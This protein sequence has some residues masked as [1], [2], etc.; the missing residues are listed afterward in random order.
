MDS[1]RPSLT[2]TT[3]PPTDAKNTC[4]HT[5]AYHVRVSPMT[6]TRG[7]PTPDPEYLSISDAARRYGVSWRT[8]RH[9]I[10]TAGVPVVVLG[11]RTIRVRVDHLERVLGRQGP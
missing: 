2:Y 11:P 4:C 9:A 3:T 8:A 10:Y 1:Y 7:D 6:T 5:K